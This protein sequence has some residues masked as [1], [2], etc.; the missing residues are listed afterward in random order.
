M[1][2]LFRSAGVSR[3]VAYGVLARATAAAAALGSTVLI[4]ATFAPELQG[5]YYTFQNLLALQVF[6]EMGVG[7]VVAQFA[8]HEWAALRLE[9]DGSIAGDPGALSRLVSIGRGALAWYAGAAAVVAAGVAA[10]GWAFFAGRGGED[11]GW[12][13][14]WTALC[15]FGGLRLA[16]LPFA[17]L[18]EGCNQVADAHFFRCIS[19]LAGGTAL[20]AALALG[21]GLWAPAAGAAAEALWGLAYFGGARRRFARQFLARPAGPA[22]SWR[23]E[24]LPLQARTALSWMSGFFCFQFFGPVL[25]RAQGPEA[26]GRWGMTWSMLLLVT[27]VATLWVSTRVPQFGVWIARRDFGELDRGFRRAAALSV[28]VAAAGAGAVLAAVAL[29]GRLGHPV[30]ERL[31]PPGPTALLALSVLLIQL[32]AAQGFYLRAHRREPLAALSVTQA[33]L[34]AALTLA[35]AP[36]GG[37]AAVALGHLAVVALV[38]L[39]ATALIWRRCRRDWHAAPPAEA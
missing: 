25:F 23:R 39:P 10:V 20:V 32:P 36:R 19:A 6:A 14:P 30:A 4:A 31:L 1:R 3:A 12:R 38:V 37:P 17:F 33:V 26:A 22:V 21:G 29:A 2:K 18:L 35:L 9:S 13:G 28:A 34:T 7:L 5:Y 27:S 24:I 8:S 15:L 11:V 16:G